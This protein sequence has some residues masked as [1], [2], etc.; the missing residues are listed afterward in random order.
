MAK[1]LFKAVYTRDGAGGLSK[2]GG[3]RRRAALT[4]TIESMGGGVETFYYAFGETDLYIIADLPDEIAAAAIALAIA[5]A[6]VLEITT[7]VLVTPETIDA[8][9]ER[10]VTYRT[11]GT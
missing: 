3:V 8:A 9:V 2:E 7:T 5:R 11:P 6:G 4:Q 10:S 1:F